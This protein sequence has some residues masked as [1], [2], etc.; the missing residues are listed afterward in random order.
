M[1]ANGAFLVL[2]Q[3]PDIKSFEWHPSMSVET[4]GR[5]AGSHFSGIMAGTFTGEILLINTTGSGLSG[6]SESGQF[7][8]YSMPYRIE[9]RLINER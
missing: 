6:P 4:M 5:G 2:S 3:E 1:T 9:K 7:G 8:R